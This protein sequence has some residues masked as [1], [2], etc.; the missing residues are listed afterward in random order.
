MFAGI[1]RKSVRLSATAILGGMVVVAASGANHSRSDWRTG[2]V[3][4]DAVPGAGMAHATRADDLPSF[5]LRSDG[6]LRNRLEPNP[7]TYG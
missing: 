6:L 1:I 5:L 4:R 2:Q 3:N 7:L